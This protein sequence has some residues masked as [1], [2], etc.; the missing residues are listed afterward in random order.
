PRRSPDLATPRTLTRSAAADAEMGSYQ[1]TVR[2]RADGMS[3]RTATL[4]LTISPAPTPD[5]RIVLE[6]GRASVIQGRGARVGITIERL[7][8]FDGPIDL[9]VDGAPAG[10]VATLEGDDETNPTNAEAFLSLARPVHG[11][12]PRLPDRGVSGGPPRTVVTGQ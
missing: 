3:D 4:S 6:S 8:G 5:F 9:S 7:N 10:M 11:R 12:A 2:A 1:L